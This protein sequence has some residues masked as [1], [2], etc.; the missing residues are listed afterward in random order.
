[1]AIYNTVNTGKIIRTWRESDPNSMTRDELSTLIGV[2]ASTIRNYEEFGRE[3]RLTT[4]IRMD[5]VK[6]GLLIQLLKETQPIR[7]LLKLRHIEEKRQ[8]PR[9]GAR[10]NGHAATA[11]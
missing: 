5:N 6:A 10:L 4:L 9:R 8:A 2:S 7:Q 1:M 3:P 11:R